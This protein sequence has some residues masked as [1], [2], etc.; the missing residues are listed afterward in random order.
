MISYSFQLEN[1][2]KEFLHSNCPRMGRMPAD[3][4]QRFILELNSSRHMAL[5]SFGM[6]NLDPG[7]FAAVVSLVITYIIIIIQLN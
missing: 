2:M 5:N 4:E 6:Y 7:F 1:G 3:R